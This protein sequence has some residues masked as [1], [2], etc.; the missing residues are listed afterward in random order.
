LEATYKSPRP[1]RAYDIHISQ[2]LP[3]LEEAKPLPP[4]E[5]T[6]A[7]G[8]SEE[9][10]PLS[11]VPCTPRFTPED[12]VYTNGSNIK[13][14]DQLGAAVVHIASRTT[15]YI[16]VAWCD[17]TRSIMRAE[18]VALH[19]ALFTFEAH[20]WLGIFA[21][22]LSSMHSTINRFTKQYKYGT[23]PYGKST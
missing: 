2:P 6:Q 18:L 12:W 3:I 23:V 21:D 11:P 16:D 19:T 4:R 8:I 22:S 13:G 1:A 14:H 9:D 17:E 20:P 15:L 7:Y 5:I 10:T